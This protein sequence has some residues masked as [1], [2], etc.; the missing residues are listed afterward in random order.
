VGLSKI[1]PLDNWD[2]V[3]AVRSVY[4]NSVS[5]TASQNLVQ[6]ASSWTVNSPTQ[7]E[8]SVSIAQPGFLI[9]PLSYDSGWTV[10][11]DAGTIVQI[12]QYQGLM[13]I[14]LQAGSYRLSFV[15]AAYRDSLYETAVVYVSGLAFCIIVVDLQR[16]YFA[17]RRS[18]L[19]GT[20]P[21]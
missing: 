12:D 3:F 7:M 19:N 10:R 13:Q 14:Q 17:R 1:Q 5:L 2:G 20:G 16:S 11:T 15:Y 6:S 8:L 4:D 21:K 18:L 9:L